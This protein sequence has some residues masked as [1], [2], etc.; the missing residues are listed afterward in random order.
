M[1]IVGISAWHMG[2]GTHTEVF[3]PSLRLGLVTVLIASIGVVFTGDLQARLMTQ[4]QP[5]K[6]AAAEALYDTTAPASFSLFTIGSLDGSKEVWSV[7]VP[8]VLSF[9]ATGTFDGRVEGINDLQR[10]SVDKFGPGDYLPVIPMTYWT[11]RLMIGF[12]LLA[13]LISLVGLW[14]TRRKA[15]GTVPRWFWIAAVAGLALPFAAN[16]VGWI[17]TEMGRQPWSVFGVLRTADG[18]SPS[19]G[20][21]SALISLVV[22]TLLYGALA[23]VDGVL[24]VRYA[25]AGPPPPSSDTPPADTDEPRPMAV[26]Y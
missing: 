24:M 23:V 26:A 4:Q 13:A 22:L 25:K 15:S 8:G 9:M 11:F 18:V 5:M 10:Q 2:R 6:M 21:A 20:V 19:V 17:F 3:R 12:G 16:S 14:F 1:F 7:R